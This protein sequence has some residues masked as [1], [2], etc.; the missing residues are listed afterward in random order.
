MDGSCTPNCTALS[1]LLTGLIDYAGLFPPAGLEMPAAVANYAR[2]R[3]GQHAWMLGRFVV[4]A[5][6]LEEFDRFLPEGR[7]GECWRISALVGE[8]AA[9]DLDRVCDFNWRHLARQTLVD[10]VEAKAATAEDVAALQPLTTA[11][12]SPFI[13]VPVGGELLPAAKELGAMAKVRTGGLTAVA[14][15]PRGALARFLAECARLG[16]PFK[17]TAGLHHPVRGVRAFTYA[18]DSPR[19]PMHGFL[20]VF[21]AAAFA[22]SGMEEGRLAALLAEERPE[23]F[24]FAAEDASWQGERLDASALAAARRQF[25]LSFGS[26]SFEEPVADLGELGLMR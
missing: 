26:C 2:Y 25:A 16:L 12:L 9:G 1:E 8:D 13:E 3:A 4:P 21:L 17:A 20:N 11:G 5:G 18:P 24:R 22:R 14:F 10:A 6:R 7:V 15:P 23:A 19:G